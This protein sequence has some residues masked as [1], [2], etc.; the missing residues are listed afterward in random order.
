MHNFAEFAWLAVFALVAI[1]LFFPWKYKPMDQIAFAYMILKSRHPVNDSIMRTFHIKAPRI[2]LAEMNT[3][4]SFA[5]SVSSSRAIPVM[6]ML[7]QVWTEPFVPISFGVNIPGMQA[8]TELSGLSLLLVRNLWI[9]TSEIVCVIVWLMVKLNL[10]KQTA[11]RLLEP[12]VYYQC[13]LSTDKLNNFFTLRDH[14]DAQPEIRLV[15]QLMRQ[16]NMRSPAQ[17]LDIGEWHLPW[18]DSND[19]PEAKEWAENNSMHINDVLLRASAARCARSSFA[20][21]DSGRRSIARDMQSFD[22][23]IE[24]KPVHASPAEHQ[25]MVD[26]QIEV[27]TTAQGVE[28]FR[29]NQWNNQNLHGPTDG[30]IVHR[31]MIAGH[32]I[33]G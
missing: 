11:N 22:K 12:W 33:E 25:F 10:H 16:A 4:K 26:D 27:V 6:K 18:I 8:K 19:L 23:L 14:P 28:I 5:R 13:T 2:I 32:F 15:A 9:F 7:K 29:G 17:H 20:N 3:H 1:R 31:N 30:W 21:F 24:S